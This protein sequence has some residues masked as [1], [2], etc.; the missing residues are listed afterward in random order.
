MLNTHPVRK[1][2]IERKL[3]RKNNIGTG[4]DGGSGVMFAGSSAKVAGRGY[5]EKNRQR[6]RE[7]RGRYPLPRIT[8][9][10]PSRIT[11]IHKV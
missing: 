2:K 6:G 9:T 7:V 10:P 11:Y 4:K 1:Y 5:G 8:H 3:N